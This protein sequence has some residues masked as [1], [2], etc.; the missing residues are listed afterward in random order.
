[1][2]TLTSIKGIVY[3]SE[4]LD[5][6]F[7]VTSITDGGMGEGTI[8]LGGIL[9][10]IKIFVHSDEPVAE[11]FNLAFAGATIN[12]NE[13]IG[14]SGRIPTKNPQKIEIAGGYP[15]NDSV[16]TFEGTYHKKPV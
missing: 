2:S 9:I 1:M 12:P 3:Y 10:P 4:E 13:F 6:R 16:Q 8:E 7:T 5:S 15:T 14:G 11:A